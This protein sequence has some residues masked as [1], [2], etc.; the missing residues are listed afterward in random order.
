MVIHA[1]TL[2]TNITALYT[3]PHRPMQFSYN[4][5]GVHCEF[6]VSTSGEVSSS[7]MPSVPRRTTLNSE[8]RQSVTAGPRGESNDAALMPPPQR[9]PSRAASQR[10]TRLGSRGTSVQPQD[11]VDNEDSLFLPADDDRQ[12]D[13]VPDDDDSFEDDALAWDSRAETVSPAP[14]FYAASAYRHKTGGLQSTFRDTTTSV[15]S[16]QGD[17]PSANHEDVIPPTQRASQV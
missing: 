10:S 3:Q 1:A 4:N 14:T 13:P 5:F 7:P 9:L 12:W 15:R 8:G 2:R 16:R 6:T 17:V 11:P